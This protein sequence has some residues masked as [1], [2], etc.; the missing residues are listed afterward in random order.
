MASTMRVYHTPKARSTRVLWTL[1]E[2][3][4]PYE[5]TTMTRDERRGE[6]HRRLHPLGRVPVLE[7]DDGQ[8]LFESAAICLQLADVYP[9]AGLMPPVGSDERGVAYQWTVFAISELEKV[10]F[11]WNRA[12]RSGKDET[13]AAAAFAPVG[14]ALR[15]SVEANPWIAGETFTVADILCASILRNAVRLDLLDE[16]DPLRAYVERALARPAN[17]RADA[18]DA[19]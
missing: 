8:V 17:L 14:A 12:R 2:I 6:E 5:V 16:D 15:Q 9:E 10:A 18:V 3:G 7:L 13:E 4:H 1:E 19:T 11:G